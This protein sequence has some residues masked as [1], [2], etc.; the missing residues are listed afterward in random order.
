MMEDSGIGQA[1]EASLVLKMMQS[2]SPWN[3]AVRRVSELVRTQNAGSKA[4][5][6][7]QLYVGARGLMV[8]DVVASRRRHYESQVIGRILPQYRSSAQ[9][10]GLQ[11]LAENGAG[12]IK[13]RTGESKTMSELA[14]FL[15]QFATTKDDEQTILNF[16]NQSSRPEIKASA[17]GIKG[18][19]PVLYEYLR[20]LSGVDTLKVDSRVR[21]SLKQIGVPEALFSDD[22]LLLVCEA[23]AKECGCSL[24][25]LDQALWNR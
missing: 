4:S 17:I 18:I 10:L 8:V 5:E 20:L 15:M 22:G 24:V 13:M 11:T 25:E 12:W 23:L 2:H 1:P 16:A 19:G 14:A 6:I 21:D 3:E 7:Q 9:D